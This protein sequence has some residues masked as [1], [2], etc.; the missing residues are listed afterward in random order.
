MVTVHVA[1]V[2]E[3]TINKNSNP[4]LVEYKIGLS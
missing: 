2:P 3:T 1:T 4:V